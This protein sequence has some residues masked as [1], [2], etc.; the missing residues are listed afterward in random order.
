MLILFRKLNPLKTT[1]RT[2]TTHEKFT[3]KRLWSRKGLKGLIKTFEVKLLTFHNKDGSYFCLNR[4]CFPMLYWP[5]RVNG[6]IAMK[7]NF[8]TIPWVGHL[9]H[10]PTLPWRFCMHQLPHDWA[11]DFLKTKC[12]LPVKCPRGTG[13]RGRMSGLGIDRAI[14]SDHLES[15]W[16]LSPKRV[17]F[18][19]SFQ[20]FNP[21]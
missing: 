20:V 18:C 16:F 17:H 11:F 12:Q 14:M 1:S 6:N 2:T 10:G 7:Y 3:V 19:L 13:G 8:D 4:K 15:P 9:S 5:L 21:E